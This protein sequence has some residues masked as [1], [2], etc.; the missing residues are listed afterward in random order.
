MYTF[1]LVIYVFGFILSLTTKLNKKKCIYEYKIIKSIKMF[2][3]KYSER[4]IYVV[5][6]KLP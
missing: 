1:I 3:Y 5:I 2:F 4:H 6:T